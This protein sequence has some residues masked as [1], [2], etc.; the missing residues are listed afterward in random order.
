MFRFDYNSNRAPS[1]V[2]VVPGLKMTTWPDDA[3]LW[4]AQWGG[5]C[6]VVLELGRLELQLLPG[7]SILHWKTRH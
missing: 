7:L 6:L 2:I 1:L 5:Q 4:T 3:P